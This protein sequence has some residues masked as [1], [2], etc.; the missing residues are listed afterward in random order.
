[1]ARNYGFKAVATSLGEKPYCWWQAEVRGTK[2]AAR[3]S[4]L[5]LRAAIGWP[6]DD[7]CRDARFAE[8]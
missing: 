3:G 5:G 7:G 8:G 1:M 2:G 6:I 4:P